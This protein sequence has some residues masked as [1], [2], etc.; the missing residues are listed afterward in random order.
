[1]GYNEVDILEHCC[2]DGCAERACGTVVM[3]MSMVVVVAAIVV[4]VLCYGNGADD[5][6]C[7]DGFGGDGGGCF[8]ISTLLYP[9]K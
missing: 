5:A 7:H 2:G 8:K 1:M 9:Q 6:S 3:V 4:I